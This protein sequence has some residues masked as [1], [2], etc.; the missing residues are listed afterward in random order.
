[1]KRSLLNTLL[2][3]VESHNIHC[4]YYTEARSA[5]VSLEKDKV[6]YCNAIISLVNN[7][8]TSMC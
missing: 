6:L 7:Q 2:S 5:E 3:I 1:M 4:T 8:W